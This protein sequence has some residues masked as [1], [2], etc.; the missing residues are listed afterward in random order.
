MVM[1]PYD[2]IK[3]RKELQELFR[4]LLADPL[5]TSDPQRHLSA[6]RSMAESLPNSLKPSK[7][8]LE[9]THYYGIDMVA[10]PSLRERLLTVTSEVA[11]NFISELGIT[12][13]ERDDVGQCIIWGDEPLNEMSWEISQ[14][15]LERWAWLLGSGWAQRA[16]F[17]RRQRGAPLLPEW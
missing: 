16:N 12:G 10:S 3:A 17:W 5:V 4:P 2:R 14:P 7:L 1:V 13:G 9:T 8:Q 6:L 15:I 11:R